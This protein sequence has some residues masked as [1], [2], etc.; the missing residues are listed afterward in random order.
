MLDANNSQKWRF[1]PVQLSVFIFA[2]SSP[3]L[4]LAIPIYYFQKGIEIKFIS[5]LSIALTITYSVS[6][7]LLNK[8]SDKL[9]RKKSVIISMVG[10][11]CAQLI[12]YIT[13]N[14]IVFLIERLFE[15]FILGFFFPN[16]TAS[17]SDAPNIDH[18]KYLARFNL[19]WSV[20]VVFGLLFGAIV[21]QFTDNLKFIFYINPIF[22]VMN[23]IIVILFFR[24]SNSSN[25]NTRTKSAVFDT[26]NL[27]NQYSIKMS[28]HYIPVI[29]PL[30]FILYT[31]FA[32]GNGS[33][34]YPIRSVIL[35]F[36]ESS[37]Y[38]ANIFASASQ[39]IA[40][41]L[42]TLLPLMKLRLISIITLLV[43]PFIFFFFIVNEVYFLFIIL[44]LFSG[45]FYGILYGAASKLFITLNVL[46]NTSKFSGISESSTAIAYFISQIFLGF[47]ADINIGLAYFSLSVSLIII[48]FINLI[49]MR[50]FKEIERRL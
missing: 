42:V 46:K 16:L 13:L 1:W 39:S 28:N 30:L 7:I 22:P 24:E 40:T 6:P 35:G 45:L 38:V 14:P 26:K 29:I 44:F 20:A 49:F 10:V 27:E 48:F 37:T 47:I 8:F 17:I 21:L 19:S 5:V 41:Y 43:Y 18:Q 34:L 31:S 15:G 3:L 32:A 23:S 25:L 4:M 36:H 2:F 50:N 11:A 33:L 12:F 9:G